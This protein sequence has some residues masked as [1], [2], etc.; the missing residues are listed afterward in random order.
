MPVFPEADI[1]S[2]EAFFS[3]RLLQRKVQAL[4]GVRF[5][6]SLDYYCQHRLTDEAFSNWWR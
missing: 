3:N 6:V 5:A 2:S 4:M 1:T